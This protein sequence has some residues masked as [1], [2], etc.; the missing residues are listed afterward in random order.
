MTAEAGVVG[1][2]PFN[3]FCTDVDAFSNLIYHGSPTS[4]DTSDAGLATLQKLAA[5][6][7]GRLGFF[8]K[9]ADRK[10]VARSLV[11]RENRKSVR[12]KLEPLLRH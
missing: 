1:E 9:D 6:S 5:N 3:Y 12:E 2:D 7:R 8:F 4:R 10:R 11:E